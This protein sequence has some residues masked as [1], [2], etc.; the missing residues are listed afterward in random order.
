MRAFKFLMAPMVVAGS[1][2]APLQGAVADP[3]KWSMATP[4][5]D[6]NPHTKN[7]RLFLE[8]IAR[9]TGGTLEISI[10]TNASLVKHPEIPR[11]VRL[12]VVQ[13][14]EILMSSLGNE[15]R[16]F[17]FDSIPGLAP[18]YSDS[19]RLWQAARAKVMAALEKQGILGLYTMPWQPTGIFTSKKLNELA[20]LKGSRFRTFSPA[21]SRFAELAGAVPTSVQVAEVPQAFRTG[22]VDAMITSGA[23]A[24]DTQAWDYVKYYYDVKAMLVLNIIMVNKKAFE[25]LPEATRNIILAA[26]KRAEERGWQTSE[27]VTAALNKT[28]SEKGIEIVQP[29]E[30]LKADI[31]SVGRQMADEWIAKTGE[32]GI[33]V[34]KVYRGN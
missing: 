1:L 6:Q 3:V 19:K 22:L 12:G 5:A 31:A 14:G 33:A 25:A 29:S 18:S 4:Y 17:A 34:L 27:E 7:I 23:T 8:D 28:M 24:V 11:S 10:F 9:E 30:K 16:L 15:N 32:D 2:F 13:M 26:A 21:T 20:D